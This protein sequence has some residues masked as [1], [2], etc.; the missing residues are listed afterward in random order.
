VPEQVIAMLACARIGAVHSVVFGGFGVQALNMRIKDAEAKIVITA[1]VTYRRG[2][3]I[4]LKTIVEEAVI[5][6]PSVEK[7][8][9]L[10]R[11]V[12]QPVE[13]HKEM[14]VDYFELM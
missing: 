10:S 8:V 11:E 3:T 1:D 6:A 9:V 13:I 5:N 14:E 4:P 7:V 2:K 12:E